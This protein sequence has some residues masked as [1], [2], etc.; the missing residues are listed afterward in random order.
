MTDLLH[1]DYQLFHFINSG[2]QNPLFDFLMPVLRNK[3]TWVP[4]YLFLLVFLLLNFK[5]KGLW[6]ALALI[7]TV[8]LTDSISSQLIKKNVMRLRPCKVMEQATDM[9]LLVPCG[10]GYSFPSSHAANHFGMAVLLCL[11]LGKI[12]RRV[13]WPLL[14][15]A[16]AISFAQVYVGVHFPLDVVCG[17]LLGSLIAWGVKFVL[18]KFSAGTDL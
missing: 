13:K 14:F 8:G 17:A 16:F 18:Y 2:C 4:L 10:S 3:Y 5:T 12:F 9:N 15:W 1:F 6:L 11:T 7:V